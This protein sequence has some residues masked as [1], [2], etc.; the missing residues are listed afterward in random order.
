MGGL[1]VGVYLNETLVN[2]VTLSAGEPLLGTASVTLNLEPGFNE[3]S[4]YSLA[5]SI[6]AD[7]PSQTLETERVTL[8]GL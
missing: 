1:Q 2:T 6:A 5:D 8:L 3:L 7:V 4:L